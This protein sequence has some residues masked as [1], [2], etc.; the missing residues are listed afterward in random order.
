MASPFGPELCTWRKARNMSNSRG[1]RPA[2]Y[3]TDSEKVGV[4][5]SWREVTGGMRP[6]DE[7]DGLPDRDMISWCEKLNQLPGVCTVQSCAGHGSGDGVTVREPGHLW[8]RLSERMA[9]AF[10]REAFALAR[11]PGVERVGRIYQPWGEEITSITFAGNERN[12]LSQS[13]GTILRFFATLADEAHG[14]C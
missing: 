1:D 7:P 14:E 13:M 3:L 8:L 10:N 4:V 12:S 2:R 5:E 9:E 11:A 6:T